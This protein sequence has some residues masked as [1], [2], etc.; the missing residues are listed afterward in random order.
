MQTQYVVRNLREAAEE[1]AKVIEA[2]EADNEIRFE[3]W[4]VFVYRK[5][6]LAWSSRNLTDDQLDKWTHSGFESRCQF[7]MELA[8]EIAG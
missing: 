3:T 5:L 1:L 8:D 2:V 6:N 4:L 7:P